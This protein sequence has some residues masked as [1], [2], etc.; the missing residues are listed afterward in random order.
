MIWQE[1]YNTLFEFFNNEVMID[2]INFLNQIVNN[3]FSLF[4]QNTV[5]TITLND[6][7]NCLTVLLIT[8]VF[9]LILTIFKKFFISIMNLLQGQEYNAEEDIVKIKKRRK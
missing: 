6:V 2:F 4:R 1:I 8:F 3:L 5:I 7:I 9:K